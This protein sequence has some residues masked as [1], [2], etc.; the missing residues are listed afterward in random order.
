MLNWSVSAELDTEINLACVS[1][2]AMQTGQRLFAMDGS[3]W[4]TD[5]EQ[6]RE[7]NQRLGWLDLPDRSMLNAESIS[8]FAL[9]MK[10]EHFSHAVLLGMGGSSLCSEVA[11]ETFETSKGY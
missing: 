3:L 11:R 1:M 4:K 2:D 10:K 6:V 5:S 9:Q 8:A 7:I